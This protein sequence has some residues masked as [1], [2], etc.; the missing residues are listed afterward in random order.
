MKH[1][2]TPKSRVPFNISRTR[3]AIA[4]FYFCQGLTFSSWASRIP[5][6]K[7]QLDLSEAQLGTILLM[8]PLGQLASMA[9]AGKLVTKLG[10]ASVLRVVA[11]AYTLTLYLI[12]F[13]QDALQLCFALL[14]FGVMSN[15]CNIAVN[16]QGVEIER[17]YD[18]PIMSSFH[19]AW[20][21]AGFV[22]A[23]IGIITLNLT[24]NTSTHF[25]IILFLMI[26]N[27][28]LNDKFLSR[29]PAPATIKESQPQEQE[30]PKEKKT[31]FS[32]PDK[33]LVQLGII[34]FFGMAIEG[35]MCDWG[36]VYF[37]QVVHAP[38]QLVIVGYATFT[39]MMALGRFLGDMVTAKI[40]RKLTLQISG[41]MMFAGMMLSVL[42][43]SFYSATLAFMIIG[44]GVACNVPTVYSL[45][46][47]HPK[48]P[49][50]VALAMVSSISFFGFLLGPP[51]IGYI[52][53]L[54]SLQYSYALFALFGLAMFFLT[55]KLAMLKK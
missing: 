34:G 47:Q 25:L 49:S 1:S 48:I 23:L 55:S 19:G 45:A 12:S 30:Q 46:G 26:F 36:G 6:I 27:V 39:V 2:A 24:L 14:L 51:L 43:P 3:L 31:L 44:L 18:K 50:G 8:L 11:V 17:H 9:P 38:E 53:E 52:A 42:L 32:M 21:I 41:L 4:S 20:S 40:G 22:G 13:T 5:T 54:S 35:A 28:T 33:T 29:S 16:T 15:M 10:S 37:K 7:E